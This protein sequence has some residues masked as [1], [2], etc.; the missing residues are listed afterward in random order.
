M[1]NHEYLRM[2]REKQKNNGN[3]SACLNPICTESST[4]CSCC[5]AKYRQRAAKK[6]EAGIC[7]NCTNK[8]TKGRRCDE[9][10]NKMITRFYG[11][12][13]RAKRSG[14]EFNLTK[15]EFIEWFVS[16]KKVCFYC[17]IS[18]DK[19]H[20][21]G[22]AKSLMTIDRK[23]N[24]AGYEISNMCM[25]CFR[26]NNLKSNFFTDKEWMQIAKKYIKPRLN[27]YHT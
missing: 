20:T 12:K 16:Q 10:K 24:E 23:N 8:V 26:C 21:M 5:F 25:A 1:K 3:C 13:A 22:R 27:E 2:W 7:Q 9:C 15:R 4:F 11:I 18:E 6:R 19:L 17:G 14:L